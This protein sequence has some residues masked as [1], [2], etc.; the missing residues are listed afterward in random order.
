MQHADFAN[1]SNSLLNTEQQNME[2]SELKL[3]ADTHVQASTEVSVG[4]HCSVGLTS[5]RMHVG[6]ILHFQVRGVLRGW[7]KRRVL[8]V[9]PLRTN[10]KNMYD[11]YPYK[12]ES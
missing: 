4:A 7:E 1:Y 6:L 5:I 2:R 10:L 8:I 11:F 12:A 9:N 3:R